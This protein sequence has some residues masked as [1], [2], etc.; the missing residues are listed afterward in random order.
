MASLTQVQLQRLP[1]KFLRTNTYY[2][3]NTNTKTTRQI[4]NPHTIASR[5]SLSTTRTHRTFRLSRV[6]SWSAWLD[7][8]GRIWGWAPTRAAAST[9]SR[10]RSTKTSIQ[11]ITQ[12]TSTRFGKHLAGGGTR[13]MHS[14]HAGRRWNIGTGTDQS[15]NSSKP[16]HHPPTALDWGQIYQT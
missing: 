2:Y 10:V 5:N 4:A 14:G 15:Q 3:T 6:R 13:H 12:P 7:P 8:L 16:Y 9:H 1:S 11:S